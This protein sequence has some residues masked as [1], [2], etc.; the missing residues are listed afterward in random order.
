MFSR[1]L[2]SSFMATL[3]FF[4][5]NVSADII[6]DLE[7][8]EETSALLDKFEFS[9]ISFYNSEKESR[10][11][12]ALLEGTK[13]IV[14]EKMASGEWGQRNLG[15]FRVDLDKHPE[16]TINEE[17][18]PDQMITGHGWRRTLGFQ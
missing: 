6:L 18:A 11:I 1:L 10:E 9:I 7:G 13:A 14:E 15:W 2:Q 4:A 16:M 3:A 17:Y 8:E 5:N 12:N